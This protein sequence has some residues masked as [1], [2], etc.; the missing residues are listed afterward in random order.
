MVAQLIGSLVIP[1][2]AFVTMFTVF[3]VLK[4]AGFLRVSPEEET[5][6]LDVSEHGMRAYTGESL[7]SVP[8]P[9]ATAT[10]A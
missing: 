10:S 7:P 9:A 8:S 1:A 6:G 5:L 4:L 2:W 3:Y